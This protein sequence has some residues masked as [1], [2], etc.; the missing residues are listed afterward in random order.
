MT[1]RPQYETVLIEV[2]AYVDEYYIRYILQ[3]ASVVIAL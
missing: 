2:V 1:Q 3:A